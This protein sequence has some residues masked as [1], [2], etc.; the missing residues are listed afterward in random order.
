MNAEPTGVDPKLE[1]SYAMDLDSGRICLLCAFVAIVL[2]CG[3]PARAQTPALFEDVHA[4]A[5][6]RGTYGYRGMPGTIVGAVMKR[7]REDHNNIPFLNMAYDGLEQTTSVTRIEAFMH[8]PSSSTR[9]AA[10][11]ARRPA[12]TGR[13]QA[14][15]R[16]PPAMRRSCRP[17]ASSKPGTA[18][19]IPV[20]SQPPTCTATSTRESSVSEM[21]EI[22][23]Q[24]SGETYLRTAFRRMRRDKAGL[25]G[26]AIPSRSCRFHPAMPGRWACPKCG[27]AFCDACVASQHGG[28]FCRRCGV[29]CSALEVSYHAVI[30][31]GFFERLPG[32][33]VYPLRGTGV[34]IV[35]VPP[36]I[37]VERLVNENILSSG[38]RCFPVVSKG[39]AEGF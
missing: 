39:H 34:L 21:P 15:R 14:Q 11:R 16:R 23:S 25:A 37:T 5:L 17:A 4:V 35:I 20:F 18:S 7:Y 24:L 10:E 29:P 33:F 19:R 31:K 30:E 2:A 27:H 32:A 22:Q 13:P 9:P 38:H 6:P 26:A 1:R 12:G 36:D 8:Q 28:K 3:I